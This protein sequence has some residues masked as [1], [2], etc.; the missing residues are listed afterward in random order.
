MRT[1]WRSLKEVTRYQFRGLYRNKV[2]LFFNL[3]FP[4]LLVAIFGSLYGS[5]GVESGGPQVFD[6][7]LPGQLTVMLLSAG[8]VTV[9]IHVA[10]QRQTGALRHLFTT[11][12]SVGV[13]ATA[14]ITANLMMAVL[15]ICILYVFS[16][17]L[18]GV[19]APA[20]L[21]GTI[22]VLALCALTSLG[23][24]LFVGTFVRGEEAA[25]AVT[26]P[27]FMI[28]VFFGNAAMPLDTIENAPQF[29]AVLTP[30]VPTTFMTDAL[31]AVM[32]YGQGL[33]EILP[34]LAVLSAFS[35]VLLGA[36]LWRVRRQHVLV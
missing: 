24:G 6:Y 13:W 30:F 3:I 14:R 32:M 36:A 33:G 16:W 22:V 29:L 17:L 23:M 12:L 20:Y 35:A 15:Q 11:P 21:F 2:A 1:R 25:L 27:L 4:L 19:A 28:L 34:E 5:A 18:F 10:Y 7:L 8:L 9:G 31:R 26:M